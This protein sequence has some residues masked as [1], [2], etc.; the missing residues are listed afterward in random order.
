MKLFQPRVD[1]NPKSPADSNWWGMTSFNNSAGVSVSHKTAM[2]LSAVSCGIR[3]YSEAIAQL[4]CVMVEQQDYRTERPATDHHLWPIVH[5][6]PNKEQGKMQFFNQMTAFMVGWGNSYAEIQR[7]TTGKV[8]ALWPIHPSRIPNRN[9][10][11]NTRDPSMYY[12]IVIGDP[13]EL[14]YYVNNDDGTYYAIP[15]SDMLHVPGMMTEDGITGKGVIEV[16][17]SAI[18][19]AL[20]TEEHAGAFFRNGAAP[21]IA[22]KSPKVVGKE[23]AERL[24][25]QWQK[26]F[27][28]VKNHYKTILLEDGMEPVPFF[29]SPEASQLL[30]SRQFSVEEVA[31]LMKLPQHKIGALNHATFSNI[32]HQAQEFV[33]DSLM[34]Y[35]VQWEN[36]LYRKL[37]TPEEKKRYRFKLNVMSLLRGDSAARSA[38]YQSLFQMGSLSPNDI[39]ELE[40]WNPV[41]GGDQYFVPANNLVPLDMIEEYAESQMKKPAQTAMLATP[42][43]G[44]LEDDGDAEDESEK[45]EDAVSAAIV[46][47]TNAMRLSVSATIEGLMHRESRA[48][49]Q[50]AKKPES[51]MSWQDGFYPEFAGKFATA[52]TPYVPAA[53]HVGITIDPHAAAL[54]YAEQSAREFDSLLDLSC[55]KFEPALNGMLESWA[56]RPKQFADKLFQTEA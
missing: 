52:L 49:K 28:G 53:I 22:I 8:I 39:R 50:A 55:D 13:G 31:R 15:S 9:I 5:D 12:E 21:N 35:V 2:T 37:L 45:P 33:T 56:S 34:P 4:P 41:E 25:D 24:R 16:G 32:E 11:R 43:E 14:V 54:D 48:A 7:D 51:F 18:G 36:T 10:R 42:K 23:T 20:A 46:A 17:A 38:F 40:D 27:G 26:V 44:G 30:L 1:W 19:I 47:A 6:E 3:V 29:I